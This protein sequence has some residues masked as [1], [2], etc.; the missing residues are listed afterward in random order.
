MLIL[1]FLKEYKHL[2]V[3]L[4]VS[5][6][7]RRFTW[8]EL[9]LDTRLLGIN[10]DLGCS[11]S[12]AATKC[13]VRDIIKGLSIQRSLVNPTVREVTI[14]YAYQLT[15]KTG[16][17]PTYHRLEVFSERYSKYVES[18]KYASPQLESELPDGMFQQFSTDDDS[19]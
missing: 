19:D 1:E 4:C 2:P 7:K 11:I 18:V 12:R 5:R 14:E 6:I 17:F 15:K 10:L 13:L 8:L 3:Q 9:L 16:R